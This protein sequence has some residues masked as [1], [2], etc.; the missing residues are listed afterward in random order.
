MRATSARRQAYDVVFYPPTLT[1]RPGTGFES[2]IGGAQTQ[3]VL[4]AQA[5][6]SRGVRA[7]IM[8]PAV[9]NEPLPS[10]DGV[11]IVS[12]P[13]SRAHQRL[14]GKFREL[15]RI[16]RA[17]GRIDAPVVVADSRGSSVGL[18]ALAARLLRRRFIYSSASLVDFDFA[19][20]RLRPRDLALYR[21]GLRLASEIVVQTA[22]QEASCRQN[23]GRSPVVIGYIGEA[24]PEPRPNPSTAFLWIGRVVPVKQPLVYVELARSLPE[25]RFWMIAVPQQG[26]GRERFMA[27]LERAA[28]SVPNLELL[29]PR[30]RPEVLTL[31]ERAIAVVSTSEY[32]GMPNV[33]L[34]AWARGVPV[35]ALAHDPDGVIERHG[36]GEVA[37]GSPEALAA[38]ARRLWTDRANRAGLAFRCRQ[39][40]EDAHSEGVVAAD[41]ARVLADPVARAGERPRGKGLGIMRR[42]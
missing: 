32:E 11:D 22:E 3:V 9:E 23:L 28:I 17:L 18:V 2:T 36:I 30:P 31:I 33:F 10:V 37:H 4:R 39:Y 42:R 29:G 24:V 14:V 5:L 27:E 6:A 8:V 40:M 15:A 13:E 38:G 21:L 34:E 20:S 35:L 25:A 12:R 16:R 1:P 26:Q 41:W 7:C 19:R